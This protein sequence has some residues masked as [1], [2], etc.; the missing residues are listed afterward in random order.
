MAASARWG[1]LEVFLGT[2]LVGLAVAE[3]AIYSP[4]VQR[5]EQS[6]SVSI[7]SVHAGGQSTSIQLA[8]AHG[9]NDQFVQLAAFPLSSRPLRQPSIYVYTDGSYPTA[10]VVPTVALGIFDHLDGELVAR[11]YTQPVVGVT[12]SEVA[13]VLRDTSR[14]NERM[15]VMMTGV[16]PA[17]IFSNTVDLLSPWVTA[18]GVVVWGG[19]AI[20]YW[21]GAG[22]KPLTAANAIGE[23][24]T[25][26]LLGAGV[27]QYP[28]A[29]GRQGTVQSTL[30]SALNV[31][32]RLAG[33]GVL[34][35][36]VLA[37][38]GLG[39]GWYSGPFSS[40]S[41]LPRGLG[42]YLI[43]G[44]EI[45]DEA[46]ASVD[47]ATIVLSSAMN[48]TGPV[49]AE[50][51]KLTGN[52][53]SSTVAWDLPFPIPQGGVMLVAFDPSPDGVYFSRQVISQ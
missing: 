53:N 26:R 24:G 14:A 11:Q 39:L 47:L 44:G 10:G 5:V 13:D 34:R 37:L 3:F 42:G 1:W 31:S 36:P 20:G 50:R 40:L 33:V 18:G 51:I 27:V 19:G 15:V 30:G 41:Y 17:V 12:A 28:T 45:S 9:S 4:P 25:K 52:S 32:Y 23:S 2:V 8:I 21:S 22:G 29:F 16:L 43:F 49:A 48:S 6:L 38:G 46:A 7:K 35:D